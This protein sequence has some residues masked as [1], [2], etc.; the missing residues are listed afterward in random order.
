MFHS[1][2][3]SALAILLVFGLFS[4]TARGIPEMEIKVGYDNL[5]T[6]NGW[7]PVT[8]DLSNAEDAE[9][10]SGAV[11]IQAKWRM[12]PSRFGSNIKLAP[13]AHLRVRFYVPASHA[14]KEV[15]LVNEQMLPVHSGTA[16]ETPTALNAI[17][18]PLVLFISPSADA[19]NAIRNGNSS[20]MPR[21][22]VVSLDDL[23]DVS[24]GLDGVSMVV[25]RD[26]EKGPS[27]RQLKALRTYVENGG[28][29]YLAGSGRP[30]W[31]G[32]DL[33]NWLPCEISEQAID[34]DA[35]LLDLLNAPNSQKISVRRFQKTPLGC[36]LFPIESRTPLHAFRAIGAGGVVLSSFDPN[37]VKFRTLPYVGEQLR[38]LLSEA[39]SQVGP[40]MA[41]RALLGSLLRRQSKNMFQ[42]H[43]WH[44]PSVLLIALFLT[45]IYVLG[46]S[47]L[48]PK[49]QKKAKSL[50]LV[51]LVP[52]LALVFS[53]LILVWASFLN[54]DTS[55]RVIHYKIQMSAES[56]RSLARE[57]YDVG[58]YAG[59]ETRATL[60]CDPE[61][62]PQLRRV[63]GLEGLLSPAV[64]NY[65]EYRPG[66]GNKIGPM[67]LHSN[68]FT[69]LRLEKVE[70]APLLLRAIQSRDLTNPVVELINVSKQK[71]GPIGVLLPGPSGAAKVQILD[72]LGVGEE[73]QVSGGMSLS[74]FLEDRQLDGEIWALK[75][76]N[77]KLRLIAEALTGIDSFKL[78]EMSGSQR[79]PEKAAWVAFIQEVPLPI[80]C[81][82]ETT[83]QN[84]APKKILQVNLIAAEES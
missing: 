7:V 34:A 67:A 38:S 14:T 82:T 62:Y 79:K 31:R 23:P 60:T 15:Q 61:V 71:L 52:P 30:F 53:A 77:L 84:F 37:D 81:H 41:H 24:W 17:K 27:K 13:G 47:K 6:D 74:T 76:E 65:F 10:F 56:S 49:I 25:L 44:S 26:L 40:G 12:R 54:T 64:P 80:E 51:V 32:T 43:S 9:S 78:T 39:Q 75:T 2:K 68:G 33:E 72:G 21:V 18:E 70:Q 55:L 83:E 5:Y 35:A 20:Q 22:A 8:V 29:L 66:E 19:F 11:E 73:Q 28:L 3:T 16:K 48:V 63:R 57:V 46:M 58:L 36:R 50:P 1:L 69:W 4:Q 59:A 45:I 42:E